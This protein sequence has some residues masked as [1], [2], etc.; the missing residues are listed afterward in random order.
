M[1]KLQGLQ[2]DAAS[3]TV[4]LQGGVYGG[5]VI[6]DLWDNGWVTSEFP[7]HEHLHLFLGN[8][9]ADTDSAKVPVLPTV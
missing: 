6:A 4:L 7:V 8:I 5:P 1:D 3:Q 9:S 2:I